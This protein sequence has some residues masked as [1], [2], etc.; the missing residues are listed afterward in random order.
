MHLINRK[1]I[2][3]HV[4]P[5]DVN[6]HHHHHQAAIDGLSLCCA[7]PFNASALLP[8]CVLLWMPAGQRVPELGIIAMAV[9]NKVAAATVIS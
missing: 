7:L 3:W 9:A 4:R 6:Y 5:V 1:P 2:Q 8:C